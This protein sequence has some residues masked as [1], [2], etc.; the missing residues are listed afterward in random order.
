M[1][2]LSIA[3][4][5]R[6]GK[7]HRI[8][9]A[10]LFILAVG[11][12][13]KL[14]DFGDLV[15]FNADQVRDA[16]IVD[17]MVEDGEFPLLGPK[18]GG[19]AFKLGPAFYYL[20]Y[21]S[22]TLFGNTPE[23][24]ALIFPLLSL[25]SIGLFFLLFRRLFPVPLALGLTALYATAFYFTKYSRFAWNPNAIPFFLLAFLLLLLLIAKPAEKRMPLWY[26]LLGI[27]IGIGTELHTT[28]LLL[29]PV[30]FLVVHIRAA[31]RD[32][33]WRWKEL[34]L[35]IGIAF[36]FSLPFFISDVQTGGE[37]VRSF[38]AGTLTKT[39]AHQS[40]LKGLALNAQFF[41]QGNVYALSGMEPDRDWTKLRSY[42][43]F[44]SLRELSLAAGGLAFF[45][46]CLFL[47]VR[48]L[49]TERHPDKRNFL[50]V[51]A[52]LLASSFILFLPIAHELNLRF[53]I[54]LLVLP[55]LFLG[56]L[57]QE[58]LAR[59]KKHRRLGLAAV[60][61][62][63]S[64]LI[65]INAWTVLRVYNL[66]DYRAK[67]Q[68]Y[69]GI[70][71]GEARKLAAF[72]AEGE[73]QSGEADGE[74]VFYPFEFE[75][76]LDY[77]LESEQLTLKGTEEDQD[78]KQW[79]YLIAEN[80]KAE[81]RLKELDCCYMVG[82]REQIGR[83]TIAAL[84]P[85]E[86]LGACRIGFITD[87]H[88]TRSKAAPFIGIG[89]YEPLLAFMK[90][91]ETAFKPDV[92]IEN[93]DFIDGSETTN[94]R[95]LELYRQTEKIYQRLGIPALHVMGNHETR[96]GGI[97]TEQWRIFSGT[98]N[99]YYSKPCKNT[100]IIVLNGNNDAL[101]DTLDDAEEDELDQQYFIGEAQFEWLEKTLEEAGDKQKVV[102]IHEPLFPRATITSNIKPEKDL[103][104]K[105]IE[106]LR[107]LFK[108]YSVAAVF[109][110]H[111]ESLFYE[112]VGGTGNY[113][114]PGARKSADLP[115]QWL[116]SF[117]EI[118]VGSGGEVGT[119]FFYKKALDQTHQ[120]VFIPSQAFEAL[121][122]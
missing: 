26:G 22:A 84:I 62:I 19:T 66:A 21:L 51:V 119:K 33:A 40:L 4:L 116:G 9:L 23:G 50:E 106:R 18:A 96:S 35:T 61:I 105:D 81:G 59:L 90:H 101:R 80:P 15:R 72:I 45:A 88:A 107:A 2:A 78:R 77:F 16:R 122:K 1:P 98:E 109:S 121:E 87:V 43:S 55:Y 47:L 32:T 104:P 70:S 29:M 42:S 3:A 75:R 44:P 113:I 63:F 100:E 5:V 17:A 91:M 115:V 25:G 54:V 95:A 102:F 89:S 99:T 83:F 20:E 111:V 65:A 117:A 69:G 93:G 114:L 97:T 79:R 58:L 14:A 82:G 74:I 27:V 31:L 12:I 120:S 86:D 38:F 53:F 10:L 41:I 49:R 73:A 57:S 118:T 11:A 60:G 7:K 6:F 103:R 67:D 52:M 13:C 68:A 8:L 30:L 76:S 85:K 28:L 34:C 112:S 110:G 48:R 46:L 92:L 64:S 39:E 108:Q 24:I 36:L 56:L 71:T 94:A 37:N